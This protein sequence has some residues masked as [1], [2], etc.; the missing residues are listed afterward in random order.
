MKRRRTNPLADDILVI[1]A[2]LGGGYFLLS[3]AT[4]GL[5]E[6]IQQDIEQVRQAAAEAFHGPR[7]TSASAWTFP[8]N[9][10]PW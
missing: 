10:W 9:W 4:Q 2:L 3:R 7:D 8:P 6:Q 5:P 1:A